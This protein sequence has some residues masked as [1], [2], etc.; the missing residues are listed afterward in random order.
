MVSKMALIWGNE[1]LNVRLYD[2]DPEKAHPCAEPRVLAY[3]ASK[4]RG[5]G[6]SDLQEP[7]KRKDGKTEI[8]LV[9]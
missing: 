1:G 3:F 4:S 8:K 7:K 6:C 9:E 5:L 2:H